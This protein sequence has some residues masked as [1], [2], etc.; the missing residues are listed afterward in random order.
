MFFSTFG[1]SS[2]GTICVCE[3]EREPTLSQTLHLA[4][5]DT[6]Q[7]R[8]AAGASASGRSTPPFDA[9]GRHRSSFYP[10]GSERRPT[11][12]DEARSLRELVGDA[13]QDQSVYEDIF[14]SLLNS[15]EFAF[16]H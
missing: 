3:T 4:V 14:W 13:V 15:T 7:G 6:V 10:C 5:G 9:G 8:L 1:R 12:N 2:R 11:R 16:N